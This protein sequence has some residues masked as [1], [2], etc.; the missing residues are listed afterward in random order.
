MKCKICY[1]SVRCN[2]HLSLIEQKLRTALP[3]GMYDGTMVT[4]TMTSGFEHFSRGIPY[5]NYEGW[6]QGFTIEGFGVKYTHE[7]LDTAVD[8]WITKYVES[9]PEVTIPDGRK[10]EWIQKRLAA[11]SPKFSGFASG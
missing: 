9:L 4:I 3:Y 6:G 1:G 2:A 7:Y 11:L 10:K 5:H 8:G